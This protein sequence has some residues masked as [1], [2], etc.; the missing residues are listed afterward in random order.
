[1]IKENQSSLN[2]KQLEIILKT[3]PMIDDYHT[4]IRDLKDIKTAEEAFSESIKNNESSFDDFSVEDMKESLKTKLITVYSSHPI[5]NGVFV[6]PSKMDAKS[7]AGN[8]EIYQ[9]R[10]NILDIAWID[11]FEGQ[12]AKF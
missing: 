12:Y 10:V 7:Y 5:K 3:N 6:T 2:Q 4:G 8:G 9:K 1:M 11:Q